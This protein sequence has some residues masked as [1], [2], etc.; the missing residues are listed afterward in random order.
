MRD[1]SV[2]ASGG[3]QE[4]GHDDIAADDRLALG[5]DPTA[6]RELP[7]AIAVRREERAPLVVALAGEVEQVCVELDDEVLDAPL[8]QQIASG[9]ERA[10]LRAFE[11]ELQYADRP[12]LRALGVS[13]ERGHRDA[14]DGSAT[15]LDRGRAPGEDRVALRVD[16]RLEVERA[17][18]R[19][20]GDLVEA[21]IRRAA[22]RD[23]ARERIV[24]ARHRLERMHGAGGSDKC[25]RQQ[26]E[27]ADVRRPPEERV[28]VSKGVRG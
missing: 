9:L 17:V 2:W 13:V 4:V 10:E 25:R 8:L 26:R 19:S 3:E 23:V 6:L 14:L 5:D 20:K 28:P 18:T 21:D 7:A 12:H 27:V 1:A 16:R 15:G 11:V 24:R 22:P